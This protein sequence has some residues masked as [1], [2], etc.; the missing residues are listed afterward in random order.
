M[1][2]R[3]MDLSTIEKKLIAREYYNGEECL[4]DFKLMFTNCYSYNRP[5]EVAL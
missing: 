3:P 4:D 2:K 5:G 1:I